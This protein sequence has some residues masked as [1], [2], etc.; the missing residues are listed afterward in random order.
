[1][2]ENH[3][4][5]TTNYYIS[6]SINWWED[7]SYEAQNMNIELNTTNFFESKSL[8]IYSKKNFYYVLYMFKYMTETS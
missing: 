2:Y 7:I 5:S 8:K 1:M 6:P 3:F 4:L